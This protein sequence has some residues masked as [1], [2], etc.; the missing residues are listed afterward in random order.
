MA[1]K[2]YTITIL[3]EAILACSGCAPDLAA[4]STRVRLSSRSPR[5]PMG[6]DRAFPIDGDG[7]EDFFA[8]YWY[9]RWDL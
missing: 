7:I 3:P 5:R 9:R 6:R 1:A 8:R 4:T 2:D